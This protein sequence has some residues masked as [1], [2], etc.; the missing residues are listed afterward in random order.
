MSTLRTD[1]LQTTDSSFTIPV[2]DLASGSQLLALQLV[3]NN[4]AA[5]RA[6]SKFLFNEIS[7]R[8]YY[9]I[10]DG[11]RADYYLDSTDT[12]SADNG[13]SILVTFDGGRVK[14]KHN[15]EINAKQA[16][17]RGD[18]TTIDRARLQAGLDACEALGLHAFR[19]DNGTYVV[20]QSV[21][22]PPKMKVYGNGTIKAAQS[23]YVGVLVAP[24][25]APG[26]AFTRPLFRNKGFFSLTISDD[27]IKV[28]G[29]T[30]DFGTLSIVGGGLHA[31]SVRRASNVSVTKCTFKG[32]ENGTA[33][34][35]CDGTFVGDN[36]AY[37]FS[38][39]AY[40]HWDSP[41]NAV[42]QG[43]YATSTSSVQI[44]NFNP[45]PTND[46]VTTGLYA[47]GIVISNNELI[48]TGTLSGSYLQLEPL[49][50]GNFV[51]NVNVSNNIIRNASIVIR[52][53]TTN[54]VIDGNVLFSGV[55]GNV[56]PA[57]MCNALDGS[58]SPSTIVVSNNIF[59]DWRTSVGNNAVITVFA[60]GF[61]IT[62]N[63][64]TGSLFGAALAT[65][66]FSGTIGVNKFNNGTTG[67]SQLGSGG[68]P[69]W[70]GISAF[71]NGWTNFGAP[72]G[73]FAYYVDYTTGRV[74]LRGTIKSG[75][76]ASPA[77]TIPSQF[78]PEAQALFQCP[79]NNALGI[80]SV[81][82]DGTIS[83]LI[84]NNTSFSVDGISWRFKP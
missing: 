44:I 83:P 40:D 71:S 22:I 78:A 74:Y 29:L 81:N 4:V 32:G 30:F 75:T 11:G 53:N 69:A 12:T 14:I 16:G 1:T 67:L 52:R 38:N 56:N 54:V 61:V 51:R 33:M 25:D 17:A 13:V 65:S 72:Y 66:T 18:N 55:P 58:P 79:S 49:T 68:Y 24:F 59:S 9:N 37:N 73:S 3:V 34:L 80:L 46:N 10:N 19:I 62:G 77:T 50:N 5:I 31:V 28:E 57:I 27:D 76:I 42:V 43:N 60:D 7:S 26:G 36:R 82:V 64:V 41:R 6:K 35:G 84:G 21:I 8:G 48:Y 45:E 63:M 70:V 20:D 23:G 47:D 39:C 2:A 15:G